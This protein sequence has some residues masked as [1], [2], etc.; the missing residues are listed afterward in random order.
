MPFAESAF[1]F[2]FVMGLA[3]PFAVVGAAVLI[4]LILRRD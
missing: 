2:G 4:A 1:W 3:T